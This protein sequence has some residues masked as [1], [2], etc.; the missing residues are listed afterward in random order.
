M[1]L[2]ITIGSEHAGAEYA[3]RLAEWLQNAGHETKLIQETSELC[4][5]PAIAQVV[6]NDVLHNRCSLAILI[7]GTGIGMSMA[8]GKLPGIRAALCTNTYMGKMAKMH[9]NANVLVFGS[10]VIGFAHL[11]D[12]LTAF[13]KADYEGGR[14]EARLKSLMELDSLYRT[15]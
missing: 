15:L 13:M 5:Y 2:K 6:C 11:L 1:A 10:R 14:H 4:E 3:C 7:C 12:I 8:A 9:N